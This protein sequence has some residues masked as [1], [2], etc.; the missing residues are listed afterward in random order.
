MIHSSCIILYQHPTSH[1]RSFFVGPTMCI[2]NQTYTCCCLSAL[3]SLEHQREH[4]TEVPGSLL[5]HTSSLRARH[6]LPRDHTQN[7]HATVAASLWLQHK[8]VRCDSEHHLPIFYVAPACVASRCVAGARERQQCVGF[9]QAARAAVDYGCHDCDPLYARPT[10][11]L[12]QSSECFVTRPPV[13]AL[14]VGCK[15]E[16]TCFDLN[17]DT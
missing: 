5:A 1:S 11:R 17:T 9:W 15:L 10:P 16:S 3:A 2:Y 12:P 4:H 14:V 6:R 8:L 7:L 13:R